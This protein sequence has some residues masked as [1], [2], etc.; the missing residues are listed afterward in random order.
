MTL[1]A[2]IL[3]AGLTQ[4][5][6]SSTTYIYKWVDDKGVTHYSQDEPVGIVAEKIDAQTLQPKKIG[7][8]SPTKKSAV[9]TQTQVRDKGADTLQ[10]QQL[11]EKG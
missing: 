6:L 1:A 4:L 5:S 2:L 3:T 10:S 11:C 7:S 8:V 9:K